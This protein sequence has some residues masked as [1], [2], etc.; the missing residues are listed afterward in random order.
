MSKTSEN[1]LRAENEHLKERVLNLE[2]QLIFLRNKMEI[3][4]SANKSGPKWWLSEPNVNQG[5]ADEC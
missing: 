2:R 5:I 3:E 4:V 1:E